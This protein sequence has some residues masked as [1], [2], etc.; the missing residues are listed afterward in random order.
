MI[1]SRRLLERSRSVLQVH[2]ADAPVPSPCLAVCTMDASAGVC[3]G[4]FRTL[5][6]IAEWS[7]AD[8]A[9]KRQIWRD[10]QVRLLSS[11]GGV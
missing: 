4:C 11:S 8:A 10:I 5:S 7:Q 3:K 2:Q 9:R 1:P 6:E